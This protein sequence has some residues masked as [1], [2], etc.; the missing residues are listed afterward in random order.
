MMCY[1]FARF[2]KTLRCSPAMAAGVE[3]RLW[4]ISDIVATIEAYENAK[5]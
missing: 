2:H 3:N 4:E 5:K 1:N